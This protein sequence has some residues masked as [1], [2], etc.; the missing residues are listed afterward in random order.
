MVIALRVTLV[1]PTV[2]PRITQPDTGLTAEFD[3]ETMMVTIAQPGPA[4]S[5]VPRKP[6]RFATP[7]ELMPPLVKKVP[8]KFPCLLASPRP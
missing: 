4:R 6:T 1:L 3:P 7:R 8:G 5:L 2:R